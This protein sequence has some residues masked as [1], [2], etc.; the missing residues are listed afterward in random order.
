[1][2][3][4]IRKTADT[5][6]IRVWQNP[7]KPL[8]N[9]LF[10]IGYG[11]GS[12]AGLIQ[13]SRDTALVAK[14]K[15]FVGLGTNVKTTHSKTALIKMLKRM[16]MNSIFK[17]DLVLADPDDRFKLLDA[18]CYSRTGMMHE[19]FSRPQDFFYFLGGENRFIEK[20]KVPFYLTHLMSGTSKTALIHYAQ[21]SRTDRLQPLDYSSLRKSFWGGRQEV[22]LEFLLVKK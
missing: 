13:L 5:R 19:L 11:Q 16:D 7:Q 3:D 21:M 9:S 8:V 20:S 17:E 22:S 12:L 4:V 1:M 6:D 10:Y 18:V 14:I 2:G 15:L